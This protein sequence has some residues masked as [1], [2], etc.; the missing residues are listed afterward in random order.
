MQRIYLVGQ[1]SPKYEITYSWR[2]K[3]SKFFEATESIEIIDPCANSFNQ[4]VLKKKRYAINGSERVLGIDVL[5]P[6]DLTYVLRSDIAF[7]NLNHYDPDK[8]LLGSFF[9]MAWYYMHPEKTVI[10]FAEDL[11][12][13]TCQHPFV[14]KAVHEW[15]KNEDEACFIVDRYFVGGE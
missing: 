11:D 14:R 8:P 9:E 6:K 1:I 10:A 5:P 13:Y 12:D 7:V 3:V 2:K 15:C 4:R